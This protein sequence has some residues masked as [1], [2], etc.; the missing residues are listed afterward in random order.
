M[1]ELSLRTNQMNYYKHIA[2][3]FVLAGFLFV[4]VKPAISGL[5]IMPTQAVFGSRD[6]TADI[7][8][9]NTSS[10]TGTYRMGW[11]YYKQQEDGSYKRV[12]GPLDPNFDADSM[13]VFS[14]RQVTL[15]PKGRQR[16]RMSLRRPPN[17]P[18]G[19]Y[20]AHLKVQQIGSQNSIG[21]KTTNGVDTKVNVNVGFAVPII[22]RQGEDNTK[23][24]IS[25]PQFTPPPGGNDTRPR[26]NITL[27]RTG[28]QGAMGRLKV[29]WTPKG[30]KEKE[31][32]T[33]N[34]VNIYSEIT[35]RTARIPLKENNIN[36][37]TIRILYEGDG[38]DDGKVFDNRSFPI[39]G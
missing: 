10:E 30:G 23:V 5:L 22:V 26:L 18:D 37:G 13:I 15:P 11:M 31:V 27:N 38:P 25:S 17:L 35:K 3:L 33:L 21:A 36:S 8:V 32:G 34:N 16:I 39:G 1:R 19:E 7:T 14:P 24:S 12:K 29:Y 2:L 20:R 28:N 4:P 9:V 6:R